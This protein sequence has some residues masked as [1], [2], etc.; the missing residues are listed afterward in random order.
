MISTA[1]IIGGI[2]AGLVL[3]VALALRGVEDDFTTGERLGV[4]R[5]RRR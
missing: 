5:R 4:W 3:L 2:A 1:L